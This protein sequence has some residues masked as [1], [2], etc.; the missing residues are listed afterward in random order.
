MDK[1]VLDALTKAGVLRDDCIVC[2]GEVQKLYADRFESA[3][4]EVTISRVEISP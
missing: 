3:H 4:I 2:A 1:A